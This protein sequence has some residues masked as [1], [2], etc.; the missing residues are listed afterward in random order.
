MK[1]TSVFAA[2]A[3][4]ALGSAA[5]GQNTPEKPKPAPAPAAAEKP[6]VKPLHVGDAA[7]AIDISDWVKGDKVA[8]FEPGKVYVVEFWATWCPPCRAS[9]PHLTQLQQEYKDYPVT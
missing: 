3:A 4:L 2:A 7:P 9:M 8:K 6:A 1:Q 5:I